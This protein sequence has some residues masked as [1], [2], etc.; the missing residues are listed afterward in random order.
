M[1]LVVLGG[2]DTV[3]P[4]LSPSVRPDAA[5]PT[6]A[7]ASDAPDRTP[8]FVIT[9]S[10][11][12][13]ASNVAGDAVITVRFS[14]PVHRGTVAVTADDVTVGTRSALSEDDILLTITPDAP[15]GADA[16]VRV[17]LQP[18]FGD[19]AGNPLALPYT[20]AFDVGDRDAPTVVGS[21]PAQAS[22]S[23]SARLEAITIT[24]S[25]LMD[26]SRG[27]VTLSG[28]PGA[29]GPLRW[30]DG[31][32]VRV[33][34]SGLGYE[35]TYA[36]TFSSFADT[37][38]NPLDRN[39]YLIAGVLRLT[40]GVD[41]D[42]PRV[43]DSN[44]SEGQL[45]V[46][47]RGVPEARI[48][49]DEPMDPDAGIATL[50][51]AGTSSALPAS[52]DAERRTLSLAITGRLRPDAPHRIVL[53]GFRDAT[54][55]AIDPIPLLGDG[56]LDFDTGADVT[57][58]VVVY[59]TPVEASAS[60]D[61]L[62][63]AIDVIFDRGMDTAVRALRVDDGIAPFAA[64]VT[65][66]LAG[67]IAT[68]DVTRRI[69]TG[70]RYRVDLSA[71]VDRTGQPIASEHP[72]LSDGALDF[73]TR[74]PSGE[75]CRD[76]VGIAEATATLPSGG[77]EWVF[78]PGSLRIA[79]EGATCRDP[80][81]SSSRT[82]DAVIRYTK[83]S[84]AGS[85]GGRYLH[86]SVVTTSLGD[87]AS[88]A[89][90]RDVCSGAEPMGI[91]AHEACLW[92]RWSWDT[93][94]DVGP[95]TYFVWGGQTG[96]TTLDGITVRIEELAA[97]PE[98][99][100]CANPFD[101]RSAS[102]SML[103]AEHV[104][105]LAADAF[106]S[107][108]AALTFPSEGAAVCDADGWQGSDMVI[109]FDKASDASLLSVIVE[110]DGIG[111][112]H[113]VNVELRAA[114]TPSAT[115]LSCRTRV[116]DVFGPERL[117]ARALAGPVYLWVAT[118]D[119]D[120]RPAPLRVRVREIPD[121][122]GSSCA[123]AI[124][125]REGTNP[126]SPTSE[127]RLDP[128]SCMSA[129]IAN[130]HLDAPITWYRATSTRTAT[131]F[132]T[133]VPGGSPDDAATL[134]NVALI[135][136]GS[137]DE[138]ACAVDG[139]SA[140][141]TALV[142]AGRDVCVAVRGGSGISAITMTSVD[143]TG[144]RGAITD[145]LISPPV[146][147]TGAD[148]SITSDQWMVVTPTTLYLGLPSSVI[149]ASRAGGVRAEQRVLAT[150][151]LGNAGIRVGEAVWALDDSTS[152]GATSRLIRMVDPSGAAALTAWDPGFSWP[153]DGFDA[154]AYDG[155]SILVVNDGPT[156]V[157]VRRFDPLVPGAP[158]VLGVIGA[159]EIEVIGAAA[160][161][162]WIY[163]AGR[164]GPTASGALGVFRVRRS[165]LGTSV[166][167]LIALV[168]VTTSATGS[169][170]R[171]RMALS[172]DDPIAAAHLY[173][174]DALGDVHAVID[175]A[176]ASPTHI[177]VVSRWGTSFDYAMAFDPTTDEL[178]V[179]ETESLSTGRFL[180]VR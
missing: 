86:V 77:Y 37:A 85:A 112:F 71:L 162:T 126:I 7:G 41:R 129:H 169:T 172:I 28:G 117:T 9:T 173:V 148:I 93:Y 10:P 109:A 91:E 180:R 164:V 73:D 95:G 176:G 34:L 142:P 141:V 114:C 147:D 168:P 63:D 50:E 177:G 115:S 121:L 35:T 87:R 155:A 150:N 66:N 78:G 32:T 59:S 14:E 161:A 165:A 36:C 72:Y 174:R 178:F 54:G 105:D 49:F 22:A 153:S 89:V 55:N 119:Q 90:Y 42:G 8:P 167:E 64:D 1:C 149:S 18:D 83:T 94:L 102:H 136:A 157:S 61:H 146:S 33:P 26:A 127:A 65:W 40:T 111:V 122:P 106:A 80:A 13:G 67:T 58:P 132:R 151:L 107:P 156:N 99:E 130:G 76:E 100:G 43:L 56:A 170:L 166:P 21:T 179:L 31:R 48:V 84:G 25:E 52:F 11:G 98:G 144:I 74:T 88:L 60:A 27:A 139:A 15:L 118:M 145:L 17:T 96:T 45:N 29:L 53:T 82:P 75:Q 97:I 23:L 69:H 143:Y 92:D 159:S 6:D 12:D 62:L 104:W 131:M 152:A 140:P 68:L 19:Q 4:V 171:P 51:V 57:A 108:D 79:D 133:D 124:P 175:P 47:L 5:R 16:R 20:F 2:C 138:L 113:E 137:G 70:R 3:G 44:P 46:S 38:G 163:F 110:P 103:G 116:R 154:M 39:T 128:P 24:F 135:D 101:V 81:A 160:D 30:I 134:G 123:N 125:L 158:T 120:A